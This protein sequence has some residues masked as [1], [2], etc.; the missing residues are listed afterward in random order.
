VGLFAGPLF[1]AA[2]SFGRMNSRFVT[3][4]DLLAQSTE[5][6]RSAPVREVQPKDFI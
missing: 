1:V 4:R 6:P 5:I 2:N 3:E